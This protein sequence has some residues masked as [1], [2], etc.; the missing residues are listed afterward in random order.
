MSESTEAISILAIINRFQHPAIYISHF[1]I[2]IGTNV[3]RI[4]ARSCW[5][6]APTY[7]VTLGALHLHNK[8]Q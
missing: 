5:D 1:S 2:N 4:Y 7:E 6:T 8:L 3:G